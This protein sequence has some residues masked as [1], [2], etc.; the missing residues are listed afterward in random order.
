MQ[1][2]RPLNDDQVQFFKDNGYVVL[3][4]LI[5]PA[6]V[7]QWRE[8]MWAHLGS[9]PDDPSTWNREYVVKDYKPPA[10]TEIQKLDSIKEIVEQLGGGA[11]TG[12]GAG[13]L[14]RWPE[15][16]Q[17]DEWKL[18]ENGH[19]DGYGPGGWSHMMLGATTYLEDV[20][21]RGGG[22]TYW[23]KSHLAAWKYL[24]KNPDHVDGRFSKIEGFTWQWFLEGCTEGPCEFVAKAGDVVFWHTYLFHTG[25]M[26]VRS[27]PR[28][29]F[30]SRWYHEKSEDIKYEIPADLWKYWAI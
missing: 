3:R 4:N 17:P 8:A 6:V 18:P 2:L 14:I 25:S 28:I 22:F 15:T 13:P 27:R 5:D 9:D 24:L 1:S 11:F 20:E 12:G 10:G 21:H 26:N 16:E 30:F 23:P 29:G 19:I 7:D